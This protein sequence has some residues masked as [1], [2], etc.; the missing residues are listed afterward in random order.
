MANPYGDFNQPLFLELWAFQPD[1]MNKGGDLAEKEWI[2]MDLGTESRHHPGS[3]L[4]PSGENLSCSSAFEPLLGCWRKNNGKI[5]RCYGAMV[6]Q[7][8]TSGAFYGHKICSR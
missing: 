2:G 7:M 6:S 4:F 8:I 5:P 3:V 1:C